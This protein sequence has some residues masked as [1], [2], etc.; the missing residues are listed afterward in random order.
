MSVV[1]FLCGGGWREE[2]RAFRL[3]GLR[4]WYL[5]IIHSFLS[6]S[7]TEPTLLLLLL[8][9][10]Y[11]CSDSFCLVPLTIRSGRGGVRHFTCVNCSYPNN[12]EVQNPSCSHLTGGRLR[13]QNPHIE[14]LARCHTVQNQ[15]V[16]VESVFMLYYFSVFEL[17]HFQKR[18]FL[19]SLMFFLLF[20][21][22]E[23]TL[24]T[25][26]V[27]CVYMR[28]PPCRLFAVQRHVRN[29][30]TALVWWPRPR[31]SRLS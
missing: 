3:E 10:C 28:V 9:L 5:S 22:A 13:N 14:P 31:C 24:Y 6:D 30:R 15:M 29:Q 16:C 1:V 8:L 19:L 4:P 12:L 27:T 2:G 7:K 26:R 17:G 23:H 25:P 20:L 18:N 11:P 21:L